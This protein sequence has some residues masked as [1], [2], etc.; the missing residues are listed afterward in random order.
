MSRQVTRQGAR[1]SSYQGGNHA[2]AGTCS[3]ALGQA[4]PPLPVCPGPLQQLVA[5]QLDGAVR[6]HPQDLRAT[7]GSVCNQVWLGH[8]SIWAGVNTLELL[9]W[10]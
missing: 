1:E 10:L 9:S 4:Q 6:N 5:S 8:R 3:Q 2:C 7:L